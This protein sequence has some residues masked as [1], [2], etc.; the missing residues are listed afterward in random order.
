MIPASLSK[1]LGIE[2]MGA[3]RRQYGS[4]RIRSC[5]AVLAG[6]LTLSG[7]ISLHVF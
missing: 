6:C 3:I 2:N 7:C 5:L 4:I 1:Q